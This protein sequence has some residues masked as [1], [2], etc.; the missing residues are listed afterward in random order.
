MTTDITCKNLSFSY[1]DR[2]VLQNVSFTIRKGQMTAIVGPSGAGK[3]TLIHLL[4]RY[5]D[6]PRNRFS[7][8]KDIRSFTLDSYLAHVAI[9]SQETL[10]L[11][12]SL[13]NNILYGLESVPDEDLQAVIRR[14]RLFGVCRT[15]AARTQTLVGDRG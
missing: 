9:V 4:M 12:D 6:C 14:A 2:E 8:G 5:Y 15:I 1:N 13:R 11:H 7:D 3:S 10:L